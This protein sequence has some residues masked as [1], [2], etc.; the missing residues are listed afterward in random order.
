MR[1]LLASE[2]VGDL[3]G[4]LSRA[5]AAPGG[6]VLV[7]DAAADGLGDREAIVAP[8][9]EAATADGRPH[10]RLDPDDPDAVGQVARAA[11]FVVTGGDPFALLARLDRRNLISPLVGA[12]RAGTPW[13]GVSAGAAVAGPSLVPL[14]GVSPFRPRPAQRMHGLRLCD[15]VVLA[16]DDRPGRAELHAAA[17]ARHPR[18]RIVR[19]ADDEV[20][21][22]VDG[23][24]HRRRVG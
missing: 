1:L 15:V 20:L 13:V 2:Q 5:G 19:L 9:V 8:V 24:E 7:I 3:A 21:E 22:I 17:E 12:V 11:A 18:M 4:W 16:H 10:V 6:P 14:V 23:A